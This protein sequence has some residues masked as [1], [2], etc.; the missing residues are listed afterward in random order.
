MEKDRIY[1]AVSVVA[2]DSLRADQCVPNLFCEAAMLL[3]IFSTGR[4]SGII[5]H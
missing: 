2:A 3:A 5:Y 1:E 4:Y